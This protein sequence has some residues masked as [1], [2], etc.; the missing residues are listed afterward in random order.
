VNPVW[1][2]I[3]LHL[4]Q[5]AASGQRARIY[6]I[7]LNCTEFDLKRCFVYIM[8]FV[9]IRAGL[10]NLQTLRDLRF[11]H[12]WQWLCNLVGCTS[13][14]EGPSSTWMMNPLTRSS[15]RM[16]SVVL[17]GRQKSSVEVDYLT[18]VSLWDLSTKDDNCI[19]CCRSHFP[20]SQQQHQKS[21]L[22]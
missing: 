21:C 15:S 6:R 18:G 14:A 16:W 1:I 13:V 22:H 7:Y 8:Y 12:W 19:I 5:I 10:Q 11:P 4:C 20:L 2:S 3:I 9:V 17:P